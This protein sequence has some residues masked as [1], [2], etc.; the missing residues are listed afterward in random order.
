M[1]TNVL[2]TALV[3]TTS[4]ATHVPETLVTLVMDTL[5][6]T[7]TNVTATHVILTVAAK[8]RPVPSPVPVMTGGVATDSHAQ[9]L[10]NVQLTDHVVP[11]PTAPTFQAHTAVP[12]R[13]DLMA[14][15]W[16]AVPT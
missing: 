3:P 8:T 2:P 9:M 15:L 5:V 1:P 14:M 12:V 11:I 6:L 7:S 10:T 13:S 4:E 16:L